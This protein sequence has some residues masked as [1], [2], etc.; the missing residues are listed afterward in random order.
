MRN[1]K[2]WIPGGEDE[3]SENIAETSTSLKDLAATTESPS[4]P[5]VDQKPAD[6]TSA[7]CVDASRENNQ[8]MKY[9]ELASDFVVDPVATFGAVAASVAA[10]VPSAAKRKHEEISKAP[11]HPETKADDPENGTSWL[12][13]LWSWRK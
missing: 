4:V 8:D 2:D 11:G 3:P 5:P 7:S 6:N 13:P 1:R 9:S 10:P 12:K